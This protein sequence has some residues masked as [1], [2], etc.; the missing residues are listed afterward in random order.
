MLES[1]DGGFKKCQKTARKKLKFFA[2]KSKIIMIYREIFFRDL[3]V[4]YWLLSNSVFKL[5]KSL[6]E[7]VLR[8]NKISYSLYLYSHNFVSKIN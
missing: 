6:E 3:S 8:L 4:D 5:L 1:N 7:E 2:K